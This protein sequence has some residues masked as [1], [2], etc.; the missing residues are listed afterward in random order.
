MSSGATY[1]VVPFIN[2]KALGV[3]AGIVGAG[4][5]AVAVA[6]GFLFKSALDWPSALLII[7]GCVTLRSLLV[8]SIRFVPEIE[9]ALEAESGMSVADGDRWSGE[10][11]VAG[12]QS[13]A[14][15][16]D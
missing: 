7:G 9:K 4:G 2:R 5:N 16:V 11:A 3:V 6:A 14:A 1:S 8:L 12:S 13:E 10:F 15:L